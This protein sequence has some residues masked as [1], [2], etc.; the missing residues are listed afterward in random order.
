[1]LAHRYQNRLP[2]LLLAL[3]SS[4]QVTSALGA[5]GYPTR[6]TLQ[7]DNT[8]S[9]SDIRLQEGPDSDAVRA[10]ISDAVPLEQERSS[11]RPS[12]SPTA[13]D[14][15][16]QQAPQT[17]ESQ[18][19]PDNLGQ[20]DSPARNPTT[21]AR[22]NV[23]TL[24][25]NQFSGLSRSNFYAS[26]IAASLGAGGGASS[27]ALS[28]YF[29]SAAH[30]NLLETP[31]MFGDFRRPGPSIAFD[32][33]AFYSPDPHSEEPRSDFPSASSFSGMRISENN[34]ALP[35]DRVWFGYNHFHN[36]FNQPGGDLS[37]DRFV[38]GLEKTFHG[39]ASSVELRMPIA[40]SIDPSGTFGGTTAYAG[41]SFGNLSV[42]LKRVLLAGESGVLAGGLAVEA[43]TGSKSY[44]SDTGNGAAAITIDP[45]AVY[46]T[47]YLGALCTYND[48]WFVN[49]F[50]LLDVPTSGE[51]MLASLGGNPAQQFYINKQTTLQLD[52][53]GGVWLLTPEESVCGLALINELHLATALNSADTFQ[54]NPGAGLPNVFVNENAINTILNYTTGLHTQLSEKCSVRAA[55]SVPM[56]QQRIFDTEILV[57]VN[58]NY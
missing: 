48:I 11:R 2:F 29:G 50:L 49:S 10:Q 23:A 9:P 21:R 33:F 19:V 27:S 8:A 45:K 43:P 26:P 3:V 57:Q 32:P 40:G 52:I 30:R 4:C 36:A 16:S 31:E 51:S 28:A 12:N 56:M 17:T 22:P 46:L 53:G 13:P 34:V 15:S 58:R 54:V 6:L 35:Q 42:I 5:D 7:Q 1:M 38:L 18:P 41:G 55:I 14:V 39:G 44:A 24:G 37:L 47:P 25:D 20:T